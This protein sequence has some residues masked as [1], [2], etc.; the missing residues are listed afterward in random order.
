MKREDV[1]R[2]IGIAVDTIKSARSRKA[3]LEERGGANG[4]S[5]ANESEREQEALCELVRLRGYRIVSNWNGKYHAVPSGGRAAL[6]GAT[7]ERDLWSTYQ[8][9]RTDCAECRQ[10]ADE[11]VAA[12]TATRIRE[13]L[14]GCCVLRGGVRDQVLAV[15]T[16]RAKAEEYRAAIKWPDDWQIEPI[17]HVDPVP[18]G[19]NSNP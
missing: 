5:L 7:V 10:R 17:S 13:H 14:D 11:L 3:F 2:R 1:E 15:F 8:E 19:D 6:C 9:V 16:S 12:T 4:A 18:P